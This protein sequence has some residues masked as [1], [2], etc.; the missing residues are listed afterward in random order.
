MRRAL[1]SACL[2]FV[3]ACSS[4]AIP[5]TP[6]AFERPGD[7]TFV[8]FDT[9]QTPNLPVALSACNKDDTGVVPAGFVLHGLVL[10]TARGEIAT[11]DLVANRLLDS[12]TSV[13][14]YTFLEAG[15]LPT[16]LVAPTSAASD[17]AEL[18]VYVANAGSR[19]IWSI[20]ARRFRA[21]EY[22]VDPWSSL[23]TLEGSPTALVFSPDEHFLFAAVPSRG[24]IYQI[25]VMSDGLLGEATEITLGTT[26]PTAPSGSREDPYARECT[27][28]T[29]L[30]AGERPV[31][32]P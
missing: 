15:D 28:G 9:N 29:V 13:P 12:D 20:P 1:L 14:G 8:C 32:E 21:P 30:P 26:I 27:S 2:V 3:A 31:R 6:A 19:D 4:T 16:A 25:E 11:V 17:G 7:V 10:Q 5:F 24:S 18:Q 22:G 23:V